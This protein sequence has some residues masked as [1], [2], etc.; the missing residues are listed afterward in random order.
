MMVVFSSIDPFTQQNCVAFGRFSQ[1]TSSVA[2]SNLPDYSFLRHLSKTSPR[3]CA[4]GTF[5][6]G[7]VAL[8]YLKDV[9]PTRSGSI[10]P[11]LRMTGSSQTSHFHEHEYTSSFRI[12]C[13]PRY[14]LSSSSFQT[15][16][17]VL[18][19][20]T[21]LFFEPLNSERIPPLFPH[22]VSFVTNSKVLFLHYVVNNALRELI[23]PSLANSDQGRLVSQWL[24]LPLTAA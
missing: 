24:K 7:T 17:I 16:S 5:L 18:S 8:T 12:L 2:S 3:T 10:L 6:P 4:F 15:A 14:S 11:I 21:D 23:L 9:R 22:Q 1:A 13:R 20:S 19:L